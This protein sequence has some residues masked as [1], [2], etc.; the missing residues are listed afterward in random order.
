MSYLLSGVQPEVEH[1][2]ALRACSQPGGKEGGGPEEEGKGAKVCEGQSLQESCMMES[3]MVREK[4]AQRPCT[5]T[6]AH[7]VVSKMGYGQGLC[8]A[9]GCCD[10]PSY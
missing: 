1:G 10:S 2:A 5:Q 3:S 4:W 6:Q 9:H 7:I 8:L